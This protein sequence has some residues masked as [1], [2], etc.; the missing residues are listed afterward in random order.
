M[1]IVYLIMFGPPALFFYIG[2]KSSEDDERNPN[3][4]IWYII[5]V[6]YLLV[7]LGLCGGM[8]GF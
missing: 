7:G 4:I 1:L 6:V 2:Y 8:I 3:A 5:A